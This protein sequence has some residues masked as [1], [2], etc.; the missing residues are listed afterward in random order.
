MGN[1]FTAQA[2]GIKPY[3]AGGTIE[4]KRL[5]KGVQLLKAGMPAH[6]PEFYGYRNWDE[7]V[8]DSSES[9][10]RSLV[11]LVEAFGEDKLAQAVDSCVADAQSSQL[12]LSTGHRAKGLE[13]GFVRLEDD[14]STVFERLLN[15]KIDVSSP[16]HAAMS[17]ALA[18]S[19]IAGLHLKMNQSPDL[20]AE[21]RL[22]YVALTRCQE[23]VQ[24]PPLINAIFCIPPTSMSKKGVRKSAPDV[25]DKLKVTYKGMQNI[26]RD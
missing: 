23:A 2:A 10:L 21:I 22:L 7:V 1:V 11:K 16:A 5:L 13:W 24:L 3:I 25:A 4:L 20:Q 17:L 18:T 15:L 8:R 9:D 26:L 19:Q 6:L 12:T 14:F